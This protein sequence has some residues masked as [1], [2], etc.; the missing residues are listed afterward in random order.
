MKFAMR[1][2]G[3]FKRFKQYEVFVRELLTSS[4][5]GFIE[6]ADFVWDI[7]ATIVVDPSHEKLKDEFGYVE[8]TYLPMH[9][10]LRV[11]QVA[12]HGVAKIIELGDK[13]S[14]FPNPI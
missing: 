4:L 8:R 2:Q 3:K 9:S 12:Q 10:I 11:D 5:F 14:L 7:K 6:I 13:V 1:T